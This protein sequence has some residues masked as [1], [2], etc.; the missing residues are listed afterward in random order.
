MTFSSLLNSAEAYFN[1]ALPFVIYR[2]PNA[3]EV[4]GLF[5]NDDTVYNT[6]DFSDSGFVFAPFDATEKSILIPFNDSEFYTVP[7]EYAEVS[8]NMTISDTTTLADKQGHINRVEKAIEAMELGEF[9]KVVISRKE[10]V[11]GKAANFISI[12]KRLLNN[13]KTAYVYCWYHPKIGMWLGATPETLLQ[14]EGNRFKTMS[15]AGTQKYEGTENVL[16][17][18]KEKE[19]QQIVTQFITSSLA[20]VSNN[21]KVSELETIRAGGLLHLRTAISGSSNS[22]FLDL[23]AVINALHPT[24]AV[25]GYP[26]LLAKRFILDHEN[27]NRE[28]YSGF[29]G[30]INRQEK[31][32]RNP[33]LRNVENSAY[34]TVKTVSNLYVNLRCIQLKESEGFIYV[35]GGITTQSNPELEWEETINKTK[36]IK[37]S[38]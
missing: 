20:V 18:A 9:Q 34:G 12:Y 25:C 36:T 30:E 7:V 17:Q 3:T 35:G 10:Q 27:Y 24:P 1:D 22:R 32:N 28:F 26:K 15:L 2:A 37:N 16:W 38:L 19:E 31:T 4:N 14:T 23:Q 21:L 13:Y 29:L 8:L 5:Q 6:V 33:K 11:A